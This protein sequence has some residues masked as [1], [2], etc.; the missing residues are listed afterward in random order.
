[1]TPERIVAT[2]SHNDIIYFLRDHLAKMILPVN[3]VATWKFTS[4]FVNGTSPEVLGKFILEPGTHERPLTNANF[5]MIPLYQKFANGTA[6][7][8]TVDDIKRGNWDMDNHILSM[9]YFGAGTGRWLL[10]VVNPNIVELSGSGGTII[11]MTRVGGV[12]N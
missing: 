12:D 5:T 1:M 3:L 9:F 6:Y 10:K 4:Y 8:F 7:A 2:D 11:H